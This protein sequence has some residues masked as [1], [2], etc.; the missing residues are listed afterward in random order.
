VPE[1]PTDPWTAFLNWLST[2]LIPDWNGLIGLLPILLIIGVV[3][4]GLTFLGLY[5]NAPAGQG[6]N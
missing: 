1:Q 4:P 6:S 2:I 5:W 3:G